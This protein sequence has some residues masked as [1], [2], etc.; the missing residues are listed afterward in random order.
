MSFPK[1][2]VAFAPNTGEELWMCQ[3]LNPLVYTSP[4]F[5]EGVIVAMGGF[6]GMALAVRAGGKGD[7]TD[8]HRLWH[9]ARTKQRIGSGV[10]HDGHVYILDDPGIAE[11]I[12]LQTGQVV[13]EERLRG[14]GP[15]SNSWGSMVSAGD[16]LYVANQSGDCFVLR[17]SP[18]FTVLATNSIPERTIGSLAVSDGE[19][20]IRTYENLW[21]ISSD[22][23]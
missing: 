14:P 3:G 23:P 7:V 18:T 9:H 5:S 22:G 17:A 12:E 11:C 15:T 10:I 2:V 13:W 1:R 6:N 16:K 8:T 4:L 20:F 21:C 19:I